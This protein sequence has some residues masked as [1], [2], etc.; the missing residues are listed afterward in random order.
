MSSSMNQLKLASLSIILIVSV[1]TVFSQKKS[2]TSYPYKNPSLSIDKRIEDL[3]KRMTPEEKIAQL[4]G[5]W[6][7]KNKFIDAN[8]NFDPNGA[9]TA[10]GQG[11]GQITR[12]SEK[13]GLVHMDGRVPSDNAKFNNDIQRFLVEQT[14]LGIPA[15]VHEECLHGHAAKWGTSFSQPIG[16]ASTWNRS[17]IEDVFTVTAKEA[18]VR[19]AHQALTPV[20]DVCRE[21]RWGR[22]EETYGED[23]FLVSEMGKAAVWGF[24]G[25]GKTIS[26]DHMI[27]TLKHMTGHGQPESGINVSPANISKRVI[28]E[29]FLPPFKAAIQEAGARSVMA[30][31]NEIDGIPSHVNSWLLSDILRKEWGFTGTVVSDY[32][33]IDELVSR[34]KI[35]DNLKDA[36]IDALKTGVDIELPDP[37]CNPFLL[38]AL[39]E[40]KIS[41][42]A[43]D[44]AVRRNLRLKFELGLFENPYVDEKR[45][46][47]V[48]AAQ[49]HRALSQKVAEETMVLLKNEKNLLPLK[50]T[51]Y[52]K[53]A[54]IGPNADKVLLGGYSDK[55][56]Y[57]VTMLEGIKEYVGNKCEI[58]YAEGCQITKPGTWY[59]DAAVASDPAEDSI[60]I[61]QAV[62]VAK[63]SDIILLAI[64]GN[65]QT[66]RE[67]WADNHL[68]DMPTLDLFG[69]Q[70]ELINALAKLGK[71]IVAYLFNGKPQSV[72]NLKAKVPA[73]FECWYL[74]QESGRAVA[75]VTFGDVNP[76][77]K[78]PITIPRSVGHLPAF[79]NF[80]P[81]KT[82]NYAFGDNTP[83]WPFGFGM[84][85]TTFS[86]S[87]PRVSAKEI[88]ANG[89]LTVS[90]DLKNNGKV[91][92]S[93]VVQL[94]IR[95]MFS[96]VTRPLK[97]LKGFEKIFLQAG[98]SKTIN[99][100]ITKKHLEFVNR[101]M[102]WVVEPG[103]FEIM[104]GN[105]SQ[106]SDL[107]RVTFKVK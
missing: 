93:E 46:D 62:E 63:Q 73:I 22:V 58:L 67:A 57:T 39:K 1:S 59:D 88:T 7:D 107:K 104:V 87:E 80:K 28:L 36:A 60:K 81:T 66:S 33:A 50:L 23:P 15:I 78:L 3:L 48:V 11:I 96:T 71:P 76:S 102:K 89:K 43:I 68:G 106:D 47:E 6:G 4:T 61:L 74:G 14:R 12:A 18:R 56:K 32:F 38:E 13:K 103:D 83:L 44:Q 79:Y 10:L 19:G 91:A 41:M 94:Y 21:P 95:D 45:A 8:S 40:K 65:E 70:E 25:R 86:I 30:S 92:G 97:E 49:S 2:S 42:V 54:V 26:G 64:G 105:S 77:G 82:R 85:Y 51:D 9:K 24:Q 84:S 98:E 34:H 55:P 99:F 53:I 52:K 101:D 90:V 35:H 72:N 20:V 5:V 17:L 16:L 27:S 75:R 100:E 37:K 69:K 29:S 31:Y